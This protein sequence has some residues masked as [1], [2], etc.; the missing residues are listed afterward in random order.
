MHQHI[1]AL[2]NSAKKQQKLIIGLMS[3]TSL[4]GLDVALCK[5]SGNGMNTQIEL[6]AFETVDYDDDYKQKI[7]TVFA[8][9]DCD[10]ELVT[11]LNP[12]IGVLH[13]K[14]V[15][16]CL[17]KWQLGAKDIDVIASHGQT[18]YHCPK[19][20][21]QHADFKHGTLQI[22]DSD[23]LAV[24]TGITTIGDFRQ[25]H[26]AAGGEGAPLAVYGDYLFFTSPAE[27]RILLNMGG[28]ANLTYLPK[29]ADPEA[30]FSS[31]IGPGNTIMDA[32][33]QRFFAPLHY[34]R[35]SL[36]ANQGSIN[37]RLLDAL[38]ENTFFALGFPKTTGPEVFN[39]QYLAT[40]QAASETTHL[41]HFDVMATLNRFSAQVIAN[42][43]NQ[44]SVNLSNVQVYASGG[45]IHNP[46]LMKHL[47][48]LCPQLDEIKNTQALGINPDAKEA[49]LFAIL[50]NECLAGEKQRFGNQTQGIPNIT[51]GK[52]SFAD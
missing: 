14:I 27:N 52:I 24:T 48:A 26:I 25:K 16:Q 47:L 19:S 12:W 46:L 33:I 51:M 36:V 50:A 40:A 2:Y 31:D 18:I 11:L 41:S 37:Q 4:D 13:G 43:I 3:G 39:L 15:N 28:I 34:D 45:G 8:K 1:L 5:M 6:L 44:C 30:V 42:A 10:L 32:Y 21:H 49:V 22:G 35:D 7:K 38:C 20:Q 23:H 17:A 9:R 29:S